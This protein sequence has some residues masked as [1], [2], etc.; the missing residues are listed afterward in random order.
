MELV[1][2]CI[3]Q[4]KPHV[5]LMRGVVWFV[6]DGKTTNESEPGRR[7]LDLLRKGMGTSV[8]FGTKWLS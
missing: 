7:T 5:R 1:F 2:R 8:S 3:V 4:E 6:E